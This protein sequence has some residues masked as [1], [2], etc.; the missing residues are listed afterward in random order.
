MFLIL[1]ILPTP[2]STDAG[3][4]MWRLLTKVVWAWVYTDEGAVFR[5]AILLLAC[6]IISIY[7][8]LMSSGPV[9]T[10]QFENGGKPSFIAFLC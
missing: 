6:L 5:L 10:N 7:I 8:L 3:D 4:L 2:P 9:L 1:I